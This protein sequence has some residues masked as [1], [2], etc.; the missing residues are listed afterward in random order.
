MAE[1]VHINWFDACVI[2]R[3]AAS[4]MRRLSCGDRSSLVT[5]GHRSA[6]SSCSDWSESSPT[7][8]ICRSLNEPSSH[9]R[10]DLPKHRYIIGYTNRH[11]TPASL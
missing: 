11:Y 6:R 7:N 8:S 10:Y 4:V 3:G 5:H 1:N 9:D 2:Q